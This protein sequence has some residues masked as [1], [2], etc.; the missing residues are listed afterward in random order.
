MTI[1]VALTLSR[2]FGGPRRAY[3]APQLI[4]L[5]MRATALNFGVGS[6]MVNE[7]S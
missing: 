4:R 3:S 6:D 1:T 7:Q 2:D 5:D